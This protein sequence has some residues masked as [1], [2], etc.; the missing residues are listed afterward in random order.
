M[1]DWPMSS[2]QMMTMLGFLSAAC[3]EARTPNASP[4]ASARCLSFIM[5]R[6]IYLVVFAVRMVNIE[7]DFRQR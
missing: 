7:V 1:S 4:E 5:D 3:A 6:F 2:P